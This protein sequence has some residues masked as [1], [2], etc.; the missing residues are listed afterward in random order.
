M[1]CWTRRE[2][3]QLARWHGA[4]VVWR[5]N[6]SPRPTGKTPRIRPVGDCGWSR[7][8]GFRAGTT[9]CD[10]NDAAQGLRDFELKADVNP[11]VKVVPTAQFETMHPGCLV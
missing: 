1:P 6:R 10:L 4:A 9:P 8:Q 5:Q 11:F 2:N 7:W 3:P